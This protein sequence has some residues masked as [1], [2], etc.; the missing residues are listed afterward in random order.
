M[1]IDRVGFARNCV[2][3]LARCLHAL[4]LEA[5]ASVLQILET[6]WRERRHV[7]AAGNGGS[8]TTASHIANDLSKTMSGG[9]DG[10]RGFLAVALTNNIPLITAWANDERYDAVF[11]R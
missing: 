1:Q 6:A 10:T 3:S 2:E 11:S 4:N 5:V 7:F 8:A 9:L